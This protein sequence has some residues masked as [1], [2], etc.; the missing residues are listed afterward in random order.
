MLICRNAERVDGK[1]KV[2]N[3]WD[4]A[5]AIKT[6]RL[7]WVQIPVWYYKRLEK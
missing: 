3:P 7:G 1:K 5:C 6:G 4:R 2:W